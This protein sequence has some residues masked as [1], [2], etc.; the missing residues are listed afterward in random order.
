MGEINPAAEREG[1]A[2]NLLTGQQLTDEKANLDIKI[3]RVSMESLLKA[4][5]VDGQIPIMFKDEIE[6]T[7]DEADE[8][9]DG[10]TN[11]FGED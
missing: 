9:I 11:T 4:I 5:F 3:G 7:T 6:M 2:A 8:Y 1:E 10:F